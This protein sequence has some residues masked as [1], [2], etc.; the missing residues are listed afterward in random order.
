MPAAKCSSCSATQRLDLPRVAQ[1]ARRAR[2]AG[3]RRRAARPTPPGPAPRP[4]PS[5]PTAAVGVVPE[6]A[7]RRRG[8]TGQAVVDRTRQPTAPGDVLGRVVE[9][10][11]VVRA[12]CP[13]AIGVG[14]RD[15]HSALARPCAGHQRAVEAQPGVGHRRDRVTQ[16]GQLA[17]QGRPA[18][19]WLSRKASTAACRAAA[20]P[21][22]A[23]SRMPISSASP[24]A[25]RR[26]LASAYTSAAGI[27]MDM[28]RSVA[29]EAGPR[30]VVHRPAPRDG[31]HPIGCPQC[32]QA[33]STG[34]GQACLPTLPAVHVDAATTPSGAPRCPSSWSAG[35]WPP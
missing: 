32:P 2:S 27:S 14:Q 33:L 7:R 18:A 4:R 28:P 20:R 35:R 5:G 23:A 17:G 6:P 3:R 12:A 26:V 11:G 34:G 16:P 8:G 24:T 9:R 31:D 15:R 19:R 1:D 29:E 13:G 25:P 10:P 30:G 22:G 21:G